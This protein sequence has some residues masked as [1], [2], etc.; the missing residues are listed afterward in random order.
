MKLRL[1]PQV[2]IHN[3]FLMLSELERHRGS[4]DILLLLYSERSASKSRLRRRLKSGQEAVEG[5]LRNLIRVGLI[6]CDSDL[7]F[8][9][10]Q[11]Y[12]LTERGKSIVET[13]LR[14]WSLILKE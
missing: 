10:S 8:P 1:E 3:P 5:S 4:L 2:I 13:P 6:R 14:S 12:R 11:I 7:K 9:F